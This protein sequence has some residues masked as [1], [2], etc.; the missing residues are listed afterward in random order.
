MKKLLSI[1]LL[2]ASATGCSTING[3]ATQ[4]YVFDSEPC[5]ATVTVKNKYG[6]IV[7]KDTTPTTV[8]LSNSDGYF[9]GQDYSFQYDLVGHEPIKDQFNRR[10]NGTYA[11]GNLL[12]GGIIGWLI[13]DP[14]TGAMWFQEPPYQ[15]GT[16]GDRRSSPSGFGPG[17]VFVKMKPID[18]QGK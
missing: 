3:N 2:A 4:Q 18:S 7:H 9:S 11:V 10:V 15:H 16:V 8:T 6:A 1:A 14:I 13:V 5:C 17:T 12:L